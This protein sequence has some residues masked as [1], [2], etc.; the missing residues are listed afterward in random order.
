M[1]INHTDVEEIEKIIKDGMNL[2]RM[3]FDEDEED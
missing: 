3:F 2:G 1:Y